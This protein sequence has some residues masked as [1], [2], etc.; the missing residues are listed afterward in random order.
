MRRMP[1]SPVSSTTRAASDWMVARSSGEM[2]AGN[3]R[4][5]AER[6]SGRRYFSAYEKIAPSAGR[7][8][9]SISETARVGAVRTETL[10]SKRSG[11]FGSTT[12]PSRRSGDVAEQRDRGLPVL[13]DL[14]AD[15]GAAEARLDDVGAVERRGHL[16]RE[17]GPLQ[18][19][20]AGRLH[21]AAE[22][23]L[24]HPERSRADGAARGLEPEELEQGLRPAGLSGAAVEAAHDRPGLEQLAAAETALDV[25]TGALLGADPELELLGAGG[26][27][28]DEVARLQA[29]RHQEPLVGAGPVDRLHGHPGTGEDSLGLKPGENA[30]V[31]F[32]R[33]S[34]EDHGCPLDGGADHGEQASQVRGPASESPTVTGSGR[35]GRSRT[36]PRHRRSRS[37]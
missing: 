23:Q 5:A 11:R 3:S 8:G 24:V 21:H 18:R 10:R 22:G 27:A 37:P 20:D 26:H 31:V 6:P 15:R 32:V 25:E 28:V 14:D 9:F 16:G 36:G 19:R 13:D 34:A 33:G 29:G 1:V 17:Q 2:S 4:G 12:A 35:A 7:S 30:D